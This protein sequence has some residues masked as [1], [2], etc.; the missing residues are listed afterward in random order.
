MIISCSLGQLL[1]FKVHTHQKL[2]K[3]HLREGYIVARFKRVYLPTKSS[4]LNFPKLKRVAQKL[5][6]HISTVTKSVISCDNCHFIETL[7][8]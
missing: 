3:L 4:H 6:V 7:V 2:Y 1:L 8:M 5:V